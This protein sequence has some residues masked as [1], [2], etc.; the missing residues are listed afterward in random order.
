MAGQYNSNCTMFD[1]RTDNDWRKY[2]VMIRRK[3]RFLYLTI[4]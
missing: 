1:L 4:F 2:E 3:L